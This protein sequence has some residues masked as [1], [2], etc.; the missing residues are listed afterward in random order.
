MVGGTKAFNPDKDNK[1]VVGTKGYKKNTLREISKD[2]NKFIIDLSS[3]K[4]RW[5]IVVFENM[6]FFKPNG[7]KEEAWI[8][9]YIES[10]QY[11][12][13]IKDDKLFVVGFSSGAY[14]LGLHLRHISSENINKYNKIL[15]YGIMSFPVELNNKNKKTDFS[16]E[17]FKKPTL[18]LSWRRVKRQ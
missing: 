8:D 9:R 10:V 14:I 15:G 5:K 17:D 1:I 3:E 16:Y 12:D 7:Q 13:R 11:N 6:Q 18:F 4:L 2:E